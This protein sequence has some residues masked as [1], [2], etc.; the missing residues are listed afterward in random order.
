MSVS[1]QWLIFL[2]LTGLL[3]LG[4]F[5]LQRRKVNKRRALLAE[6]EKTLL[7]QAE[8]LN[9]EREELENCKEEIRTQIIEWKKGH[10]ELYSDEIDRFLNRNMK[11]M[12]SIQERCYWQNLLLNIVF[13]Q[14]IKECQDAGAA[15]VEEGFPEEGF[16]MKVNHTAEIMGIFMNLFD[17]AREACSRI[18]KQEER[19]IRVKAR[20]EKTKLFLK[21][22]NSCLNEDQK[23]IGKT[24]KQNKKEHG[25]GK[26]IVTELVNRNGGWVTFDR[27]ED[28]HH[29]E[30]MLPVLR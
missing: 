9:V 22:E 7:I 17:N 1:D 11:D 27:Q 23:R 20:Q 16:A 24:W 15:V 5:L 25:Y 4:I 14:K 28:E 10:S 8:R 2:S 12:E 30:L 18:P 3:L 6:Q 29:V 19:W 13:S 21:I 26:D